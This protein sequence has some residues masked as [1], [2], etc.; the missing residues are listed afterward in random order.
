MET[1]ISELNNKV[2]QSGIHTIG[3]N[4]QYHLLTSVHVTRILSHA[5]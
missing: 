4:F 3:M 5:V 1:G 2:I